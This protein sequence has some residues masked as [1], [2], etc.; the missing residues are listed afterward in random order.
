MIGAAVG[1][2]SNRLRFLCATSRSCW[3]FSRNSA[4]IRAQCPGRISMYP[5]AGSLFEDLYFSDRLDR[6]PQAQLDLPYDAPDLAAR[7]TLRKTASLMDGEWTLLTVG[8]MPGT[9]KSLV[10]LL[11]AEIED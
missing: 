3:S 5:A 7:A 2:I 9:G 10:A 1:L 4:V 11:K 6:V 8:D